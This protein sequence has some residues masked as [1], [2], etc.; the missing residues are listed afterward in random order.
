MSDAGSE[1]GGRRGYEP[2]DG[3]VRDFSNWERKGPL[4]ATSGQAMSLRDGGRQTSKDGPGFRRNSP[5]WG[6]GRSQEGSRP[7]RREYTDKPPVE[8]QPT[9]SELDTKWRTNMRPDP[10][11]KSPTPESSAPPSPRPQAAPTT[12]PKLNLAKRTVSEA[13]PEAGAAGGADSKASPFGAARPVDTA[14]KEKEIEEKRQQAIREKKEADDKEKAL[15]VEEKKASKEKP[16]QEQPP[17]SPRLTREKSGTK[18]NGEEQAQ[19]PKYDILRRVDPATNDMVEEDEEEDGE[20]ALPVDDKSVKPNE[21][22][23]D[24]PAQANGSWRKDSTQNQ[25][26]TTTETMEEDGWSTVSKPNK[27]RNNRRSNAPSRALAS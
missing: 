3:K 24:T 7:P 4:P 18:E 16:D 2:S 15:R 21:V 5:A 12:R 23:V 27:Q 17:S 13:V 25:T 6:E 10:P 20:P 9:A 19:P 26:E 22:V 14:A 11:A 1:R 8:R